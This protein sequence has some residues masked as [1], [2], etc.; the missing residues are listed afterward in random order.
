MPP[1]PA[2]AARAHTHTHT[3]SPLGHARS[4]P[5]PSESESAA[6][7]PT[8]QPLPPRK[9]RPPQ[10]PHCAAWPLRTERPPPCPGPREFWAGTEHWLTV[11]EG[12]LAMDRTAN[13]L[14]HLSTGWHLLSRAIK[15]QRL[16]S[17]APP[18]PAPALEPQSAAQ[19]GQAPC[20]LSHSWAMIRPGISPAV[21]APG[22]NA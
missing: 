17:Q 16:N 2:R 15:H 9:A 22:A 20:P 5:P 4:R 3:Q 19:K 12:S 7:T 10:G 18:H 14:Q 8:R 21:S 6:L 11:G 13:T 1:A